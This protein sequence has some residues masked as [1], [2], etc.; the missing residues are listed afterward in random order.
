MDPLMSKIMWHLVFGLGCGVLEPNAAAERADKALGHLETRRTPTSREDSTRPAT[1]DEAAMLDLV[2]EI[3]AADA[4][5]LPPEVAELKRRIAE[6]TAGRGPKEDDAAL[7][8][9]LRSILEDLVRTA[10]RA[11]DR[12]TPSAS[13]GAGDAPRDVERA[14]RVGPGELLRSALSA[15][16]R[17]TTDELKLLGTIERLTVASAEARETKA[18]ARAADSARQTQALMG[19][20]QM[21]SDTLSTVVYALTEP[22]GFW[23]SLLKALRRSA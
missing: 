14:R 7:P 17:L 9:E 15:S 10:G 11:A 19:I 16:E 18:R 8:P 13:P 6:E 5:T 23:V 3:L 21:H 2:G 1:A 4:D 20:I 22:R 12:P